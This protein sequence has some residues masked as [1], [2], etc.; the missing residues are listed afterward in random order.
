MD[1][2]Y[3]ALNRYRLSRKMSMTAFA[4]EIGLSIDIVR[5]TIF[6]VTEPHDYNKEVF[7][8]YYKTHQAEILDSILDN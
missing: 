7:D 8:Q 2:K 4:Q 1:N 6:G 5:R 3:T